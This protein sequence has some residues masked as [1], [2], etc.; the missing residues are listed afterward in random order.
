[1]AARY[2]DPTG[3]AASGRRDRW[4]LKSLPG[5][6]D[7]QFTVSP[8][9]EPKPRL[10]IYWAASCG[11]CEVA[12]LNTHETLLELDARFD[13]CFCPCLLD[14]K[15]AEVESWP[16]GSIAV[17]LL[18]GAI[19]TEENLEMARLL[20]RKSRLLVAFGSCAVEGCVPGLGNLATRE[21]TLR[22]IFEGQ[23]TSEPGARPPGAR[24]Q[25]PEG[26]LRLPALLERV[27]S[28]A[29]VVEVDYRMPGCPPE[30]H[31]IRAVLD[32]LASGGPLPPKGAVLGAGRSSVCDECGK[33]RDEKKLTRLVR[34]WQLLPDPDLCLLE[35]GVVCLGV[36]TRDGCGGLCPKV[37]MPC[38][39]CYGPPEGV[40]DQGAKMAGT[41]GSILDLG[42]LQGLRDEAAIA[43]H[44]D[45]QLAA[46]P[47]W[48]GT[49][50]KFS[51]AE[52]LL[53][54]SRAGRKEPS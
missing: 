1:M 47:D 52:S 20:R 33:Q 44:V 32:L 18:N 15:R 28:L 48:A 25:V 19:R 13:F 12:V 23:P 6:A 39:G 21:E 46:I 35:Q 42:P 10:A 36:A 5:P 27:H 40:L 34:T 17:A 38:V 29:Q 3:R 2:P 41:L 24:S 14:T 50:Y 54:R 4:S 37:D 7:E 26:E 30:P 9:P 45:A 16:D 53:G 51:L 31:Q 49:F 11:G 43:A 8:P 22:T